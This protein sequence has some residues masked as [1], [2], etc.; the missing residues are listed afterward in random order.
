MESLALWYDTCDN[1]KRL[2]GNLHLWAPKRF[3]FNGY[4]ILSGNGAKAS[5]VFTGNKEENDG[6][7]F[8]VLSD[9]DMG[10]EDARMLSRPGGREGPLWF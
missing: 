4:P 10:P 5:A 3:T 2:P 9:I 8:W 6:T 7:K 1:P